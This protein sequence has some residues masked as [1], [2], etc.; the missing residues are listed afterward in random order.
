MFTKVLSKLMSES[1]KPEDAIRFIRANIGDTLNDQDTVE[2]L[3]QKLNEAN[4]VIEELR[5]KL[6]QYED[7]EVSSVVVASETTA[8]TTPVAS[9]AAAAI[10][11]EET[12]ASALDSS[13]EPMQV[14]ETVPTKD[15]PDAVEEEVIKVAETPAET[16]AVAPP[17]AAAAAASEASEKVIAEEV[18]PAETIA[19]T[20]E[21][22]GNSETPAPVA[23]PEKPT[24][25]VEMTTAPVATEAQPPKPDEKMET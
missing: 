8:T 22:E 3:T 15:K 6:S 20:D 14:E 25:V 11:P 5:A 1:D 17:A 10:V 23:E 19:K 18:S 12:S 4:Q 2:S 24:E 9:P 21:K 13:S 16:P 7:K